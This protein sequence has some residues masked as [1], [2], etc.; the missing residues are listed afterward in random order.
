MRAKQ[1]PNKGFQ[2]KVS[3]FS[4]LYYNKLKQGLGE[5]ISR[6]H[7]H[8][9]HAEKKLDKNQTRSVDPELGSTKNTAAGMRPSVYRARK[10]GGIY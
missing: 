3:W 5:A 10:A 4:Y 7:S 2:T 8:H 1:N 9:L 6:K